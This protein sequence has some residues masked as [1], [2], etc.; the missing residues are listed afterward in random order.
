MGSIPEL[1]EEELV[2]VSARNACLMN[3]GLPITCIDQ[4]LPICGS[5]LLRLNDGLYFGVPWLLGVRSVIKVRETW[6]G[7]GLLN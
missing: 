7:L 1:N 5:L 6:P 2:G 4:L 3:Q